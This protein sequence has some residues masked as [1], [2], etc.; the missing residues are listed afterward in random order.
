MTWNFS[1]CVQATYHGK[2]VLD[3]R[4]GF[5]FQSSG[6]TDSEEGTSWTCVLLNTFTLFYIYIYILLSR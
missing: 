4:A 3:F 5:P 1:L 6:Q 2:Q